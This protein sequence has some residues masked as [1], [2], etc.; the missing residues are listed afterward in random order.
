MW[1]AVQGLT[2]ILCLELLRDSILFWMSVLDF[3]LFESCL[4]VDVM[5]SLYG[6]G[7]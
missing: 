5:T 6:L 1:L 7:L 3:M 4:G 2:G